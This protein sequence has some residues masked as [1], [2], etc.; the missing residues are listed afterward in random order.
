[1]I[2]KSVSILALV[3]AAVFVLYFIQMIRWSTSTHTTFGSSDDVSYSYSLPDEDTAFGGI[4]F[5]PSISDSLPH[6]QYKHIEDSINRIT[7]RIKNNNKSAGTGLLVGSLGA[8]SI[9]DRAPGEADVVQ[10][11]YYLALKGYAK[12]QYQTEFFLDKGTNNLAYLVMDSVRKRA[13]GTSKMGHFERR[14]IAVRYAAGEQTVL[15]PLTEKQYQVA[16]V[17]IK[18]LMGSILFIMIYIMI[19]LPLQIVI[20]ISRGKAF[21]LQNIQRFKLMAIVLLVASLTAVAA[22]YLFKLFFR[23]IIPDELAL[24]PFW[25]AFIDQLPALLTAPGVFLIGKAFERGYK[26]Q[27]ENALTI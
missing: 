21:T 9:E 20:N 16:A 24:K 11:L 2:R 22:P 17:V 25:E 12:K 23:S 3:L 7:E 27:R 8:M 15:V 14:R 1:M 4:F 19:G 18:I 10:T 26:L 6:Y 13:F 5:R